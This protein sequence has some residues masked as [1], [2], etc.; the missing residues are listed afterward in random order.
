MKSLWSAMLLAVMACNPQDAH[1]RVVSD[2]SHVY[3]C[4]YRCGLAKFS[5]VVQVS[6]EEYCQAE[7]LFWSYDGVEKRLQLLHTRNILNCAALMA[8]SLIAEE[9]SYCLLETNNQDTRVAALCDCT[10]DLYC[11]AVIDV[12]DTSVITLTIDRVGDVDSM[13]QALRTIGIQ[14]NLREQKGTIVLQNDSTSC[15]WCAVL[16][17]QTV[18][19]PDSSPFQ[20]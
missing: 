12:P 7:K 15:Q 6:P 13:H 20:N 5:G 16:N 1:R 14:I 19:P 11:S 4:N 17:G 8:T 10:F 18:A 2:A 3:G 9:N